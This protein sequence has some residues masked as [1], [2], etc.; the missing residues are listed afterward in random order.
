L[1][2]KNNNT[3]K[4]VSLGSFLH[5]LAEGTMLAGGNSAI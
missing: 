3:H 5:L 2:Q 4:M 1:S